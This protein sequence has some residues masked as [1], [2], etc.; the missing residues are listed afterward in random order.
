MK[1]MMTTPAN[2]R[3]TVTN[4]NLQPSVKH[5]KLYL[6]INPT[7]LKQEIILLYQIPWILLNQEGKMARIFWAPLNQLLSLENLLLV[8]CPNPPWQIFLPFPL[9]VVNCLLY[10]KTILAKPN[11]VH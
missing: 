2:M 6:K 11:L 9:A 10:P 1:K 5:Q 3:K 7:N 8:N 4:P